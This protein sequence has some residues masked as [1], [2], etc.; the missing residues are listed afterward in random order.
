MSTYA[1]F[2]MTRP[3]ATEIAKRTINRRIEEIGLFVSESHFWEM[4]QEESDKIMESGQSVKLSQAFDA[5]QFAKQ[6]RDMARKLESRDLEIKAY[7]KSRETSPVTGRPKM[8]WI[9]I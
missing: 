9:L 4:V 8:H 5:P 1:V 3:A 7:C 6:Y 2:G